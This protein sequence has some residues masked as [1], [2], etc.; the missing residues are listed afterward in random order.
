MKRY[1]ALA[2]MLVTLCGC[3]SN[4]PAPTVVMET[5]AQT[6]AATTFPTEDRAELLS[7]AMLN[8]YDAF[9]AGSGRRVKLQFYA[10]CIRDCFNTEGWPETTLWELV[11]K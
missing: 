3:A 10:A 1:I 4:A 2:L 6:T 5:T 9:E 7:A 11:L 8:T